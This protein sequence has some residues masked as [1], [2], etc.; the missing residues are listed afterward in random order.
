MSSACV[1]EDTLREMR[2]EVRA[3]GHGAFDDGL[4]FDVRAAEAVAVGREVLRW[5]GQLAGWRSVAGEV[6]RLTCAWTLLMVSQTCCMSSGSLS[7]F[8]STLGS[9]QR[10]RDLDAILAAVSDRGQRGYCRSAE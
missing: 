4:G 5:A 9:S 1:A 6:P 7:I 2:W 3:D 10:T 8:G